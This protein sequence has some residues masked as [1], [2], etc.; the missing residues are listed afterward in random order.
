MIKKVLKTAMMFGIML[1]GLGTA[2]SANAAETLTEPVRTGTFAYFDMNHD[3]MNEKI[4]IFANM[5]GDILDGYTIRIN[6]MLELQE[7]ISVKKQCSG[8]EALMIDTRSKDQYTDLYIS[9]YNKTGFFDG[10]VYRY[11]GKS[12]KKLYNLANVMK[13]S[14]NATPTHEQP[15]NGKI[16]F[17]VPGY[18]VGKNTKLGEYEVYMDFKIS[19]GKLSCSDTTFKTTENYQA[20]TSLE[21]YRSFKVYKDKSQKKKAYTVKTGEKFYVTKIVTSKGKI[22]YLTVKNTSGKT[23]WIKAPTK[24]FIK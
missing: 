3:E 8:I 20:G 23:G 10:N 6:D 2:L 9:Q 4:G 17:S 21:A 14:K 24:K 1:L 15:G 12:L 22:T 13:L 5:S 7:K 11:D 18:P 19:K 16:R